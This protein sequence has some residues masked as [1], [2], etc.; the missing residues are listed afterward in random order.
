[1]RFSKATRPELPKLESLSYPH[2]GAWHTQEREVMGIQE[3]TDRGRSLKLF[4]GDS[5]ENTPTNSSEQGK[6]NHPSVF[7]STL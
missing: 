6:H 2:W 1:M 5:E 3:G 7:S 4:P